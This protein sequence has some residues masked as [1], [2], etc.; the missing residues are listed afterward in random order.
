M[1]G[2]AGQARNDAPCFLGEGARL[3]RAPSPITGTRHSGESQN[4]FN[5][6]SKLKIE[7]VWQSQK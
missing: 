4:L 7:R 5:K 6:K 3:R 2:I 1:E